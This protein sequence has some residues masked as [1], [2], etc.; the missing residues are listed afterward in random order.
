MT[1][2]N[3]WEADRKICEAAHW[4]IPSEDTSGDWHARL[5][6][7]THCDLVSRYRWPIAL[8]HIAE[9]HAVLKKVCRAGPENFAVWFQHNSERI[10][11]LLGSG[12][13]GEG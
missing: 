9:C 2:T 3:Q 11:R 5:A 4:E 12:T 8:K 13:E 1:D 7:R 6:A 10:D